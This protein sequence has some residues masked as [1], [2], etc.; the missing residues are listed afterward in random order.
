MTGITVCRE[1]NRLAVIH[2]SRMNRIKRIGMTGGA[3][4]ADRKG[5]ADSITYQIAIGVM[6]AYTR[7]MHFWIICIYWIFINQWRWI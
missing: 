3:V 5:L 1:L 7:I 2:V 6:A 4:A